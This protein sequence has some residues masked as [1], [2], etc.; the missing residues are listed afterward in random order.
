MNRSAEAVCIS[1]ACLFLVVT[2]LHTLPEPLDWDSATYWLIGRELASGASLY[3]DFW[4][5]K[6]PGIF[7]A[8]AAGAI[9]SPSPY[10]AAWTVSVAT[11][12]AT[13]LLVYLAMRRFSVPAGLVAATVYALVSG[14]MLLQGNRLNTEGL[15]NLVIAGLLVVCWRAEWGGFS[16][17]VITGAL[18]AL[19]GWCKQVGILPAAAV[20]V[21][22]GFALRRERGWWTGLIAGALVATALPLIWLAF[23]GRGELAW[24][25][26]V[27]APRE[28]AGNTFANVLRGFLPGQADWRPMTALL[29]A[30]MV[31]AGG[32]L[33][34]W[35]GSSRRGNAPADRSRVPV[36]TLLLLAVATQVAVA[37]PGRGFAHYFQLWLIPA[38]VGAGL[39]VHEMIRVL[40]RSLGTLVAVILVLGCAAYQAPTYALT[41]AQWAERKN[42]A[43]FAWL[44]E[45]VAQ[46]GKELAPDDSV[47]VWCEEPWAYVVLD[48]RP[49][50]AVL[51]RGHA[52]RGAQADGLARA[53]LD[54]LRRKPPKLVLRYISAEEVDSNPVD[55]WIDEHYVPVNER[56]SQFWP[57][58]LLVRQGAG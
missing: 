37:A 33:L 10:V 19:S 50:V 12:C 38:C 35:T 17:G 7:L 48:R 2:R 40:G 29:P 9:L 6:P 58:V 15:V 31:A 57:L 13:L 24:I 16:A 8:Y 32:V 39:G 30:L 52:V 34:A 23:T 3:R 28:Y 43:I 44:Q 51:W 41:P 26:L 27:L 45:P 11:G 54:A 53:T 14:D 46:L 47:L 25:T 55:R 18:I 21:M 22:S 36:W 5:I 49:P 1:I 4:D 42:G 20:A 56:S